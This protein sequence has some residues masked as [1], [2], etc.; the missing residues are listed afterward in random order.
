MALRRLRA[1]KIIVYQNIKDDKFR[2]YNTIKWPKKY[3]QISL[4]MQAD[5]EKLLFID[6]K[7]VARY[8]CCGISLWCFGCWKSSWVFAKNFSLR[9]CVLSNDDFVITK[10][11]FCLS[12]FAFYG[13]S[14]TRRCMINFFP[15]LSFK[16][17]FCIC[18]FYINWFWKAHTHE[19]R[20]VHA[21]KCALLLRLLAK[22]NSKF[23]IIFSLFI[24]V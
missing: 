12:N 17:C 2:L 23:T 20:H 24:L 21:V 14:H 13:V 19:R 9:L 1:E 18:L 11:I 16:T 3:L 7:M 5:S 8:I 6:V 15:M 10:R 22:F 4:V